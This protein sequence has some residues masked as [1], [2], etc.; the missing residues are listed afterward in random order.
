MIKLPCL[1][2]APLSTV[3]QFFLLLTDPG[4]WF[5]TDQFFLLLLFSERDQRKKDQRCVFCKDEKCFP[6]DK[7]R[8]T[9]SCGTREFFPLTGKNFPLTNFPGDCKTLENEESRFLES[10]FLEINK[11]LISSLEATFDVSDH[12]YNL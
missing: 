6:F 2:P 9:L 3:W 7:E 8:K 10:S 1:W 4:I 5:L 12:P 11:V